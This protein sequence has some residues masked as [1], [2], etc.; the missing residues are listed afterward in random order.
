MNR[1]F[2]FLPAIPLAAVA[3]QVWPRSAMPSPVF[4]VGAESECSDEFGVS[5][6]L[7][8]LGAPI[9]FRFRAGGDLQWLTPAAQCR[10]LVVG[11]AISVADL[12]GAAERPEDLR[13][14]LLRPSMTC[15]TLR[16]DQAASGLAP[17]VVQGCRENFRLH[18]GPGRV[19]T[20][21][22]TVLHAESA[23]QNEGSVADVDLD[24][25]SQIVVGRTDHT[26]IERIVLSQAH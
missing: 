26:S 13:F 1:A 5:S 10:A 11:E 16:H 20:S 25:G 6:G 7:T 8:L 15:A 24:P 9:W 17:W 21:S 19:E 23:V 4:V 12:L 3:V 14:G 18:V 2:Y 22:G